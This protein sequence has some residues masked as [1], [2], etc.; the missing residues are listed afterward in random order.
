MSTIIVSCI[1]LHN[2]AHAQ[3]EPDFNDSDSDSGDDV[4]NDRPDS[5][6]F[7]TRDEYARD[8]FE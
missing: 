6:A 3:N 2:I 1:I 8:L 4:N 5:N 7:L